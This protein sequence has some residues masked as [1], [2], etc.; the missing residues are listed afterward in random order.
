[1]KKQELI[2]T[3]ITLFIIGVFGYFNMQK[4]QVLARDIQRKNDL[5]HIAAALNNYLKDVGEYPPSLDGKLLA[6]TKGQQLSPCDWGRDVLESTNSAY[7]KPTPVDPL[8]EKYKYIY[9]SNTHHFQLYA[10]LERSDDVEINKDAIKRGLYCGDNIC[11]FAVASS[12]TPVDQELIIFKKV[13]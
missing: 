2:F 13:E 6:C 8:A 4:A 11:N 12:D 3:F 10:S 7:L 9:I 1:M 5:K